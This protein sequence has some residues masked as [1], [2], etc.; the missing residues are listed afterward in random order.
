MLEE[1]LRKK[2]KQRKNKLKICKLMIIAVIIISISVCT[3]RIDGI[4]ILAKAKSILLA[5]TTI[6]VNSDTNAYL[7]NKIN[8]KAKIVGGYNHFLALGVDGKVYTW[9]YNGYGQLSTGNTANSASP[10][11]MNIDN[12]IDIAASGHYSLLLKNNGTEYKEYIIQER[13][14]KYAN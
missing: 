2:L 10:V 14:V 12:V 9:G 11:C 13:G 7:A 6:S 3:I 8:S 1:N 5:E 4:N